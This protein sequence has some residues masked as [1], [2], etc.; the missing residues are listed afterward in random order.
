MKNRKFAGLLLAAHITLGAAVLLLSG[1]GTATSPK[2]KP[3]PKAGENVPQAQGT[4][5]PVNPAFNPDLQAP[6]RP[7]ESA[8][9]VSAADTAALTPVPPAPVAASQEYT[10]AKGDSLTR[11]AKKFGVSVA[12]LKAA[13]GLSSDAVKV[14]QKLVIPGG[15][16]GTGTTSLAVEGG[17]SAPLAAAGTQEYTVEKGDS[18][19]RVAKKFGVSLAD[20]RA[21]NNLTGDTIKAGQKLVIPAG[22]SAPKESAAPAATHSVKDSGHTYKVQ[23]GD[24]LGSI[25]HRAGVKVQDLM[26]LNGISDPKKLHV[27]AVLHLPAGAKKIAAPATASHKK[28]KGK[29]AASNAGNGSAPNMLP[30]DV[31]GTSP[32]PAAATPAP[33]SAA[34]VPVKPGAS[35]AAPA[36]GSSDLENLGDEPAAPTVPVQGESAPV[37]P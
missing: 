26:D 15:A 31:L 25:A 14:G 1:C 11:I 6:T 32:A 18:L 3:A 19:S 17:S 35:G 2:A 10:V 5:R 23:K 12:D 21:A 37:Q 28:N 29:P 22:A 34:P 8:A 30:T 27:G 4:P 13:N 9:P 36:S 7:T 33:A 24:S 20:L 16:P